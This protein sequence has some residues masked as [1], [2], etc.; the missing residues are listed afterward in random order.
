[1]IRE[2][3]LITRHTEPPVNDLQRYIID[4]DLA[5]L[6]SA[7][8]HF[9]RF[10]LAI[11]KEYAFVPEADFL[12]GRCT[13][14]AAF[15]DRPRIFQTEF[16]YDRFEAAARSNIRRTIASLDSRLINQNHQSKSFERIH[17]RED[18]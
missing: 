3:I 11:R 12:H 6:G 18:S 13:L 9:D 1:V 10:E 5:I 2:L 17:P 14:L 15:L 4:I 16:F 7:R 8:E